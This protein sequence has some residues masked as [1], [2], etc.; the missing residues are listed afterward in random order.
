M[1]VAAN[2]ADPRWYEEI[3]QWLRPTP[4]APPI[5]SAADSRPIGPPVSVTPMRPEGTDSSISNVRL[6][7][8]LARTQR[9]RNSHEGFAEIGIRARSPQTYAAGALLANGARL[10]EIY[11]HYV[12]LE[13]NG[14]TVR[15]DLQG[16]A[17]APAAPT[18]ELLMVGGTSEKEVSMEVSEEPLTTYV[19]PTPLFKGDHLY[20]VALY[21]GR[22]AGVLSD[23][24]LQTGDVLTGINGRPISDA[25]SAFAALRTIAQGALL[26]V[27]VERQG[28]SQPLSLD[29][30]LVTRAI[31][32]ASQPNPPPQLD[33][34][35]PLP[36]SA[37]YSGLLL[38][39]K[40]P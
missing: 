28:V 24:G 14:R 2:P 23:L 36:L 35:E 6:P 32:R 11:D 27:D 39:E 13:R 34:Q 26:N 31:S 16:E 20:G 33:I 15:L 38:P 3:L 25:A 7:L 5:K 10:T 22:E 4:L 21:P 8:L 29:G 17:R 30:S 1:V 12:V 9:G 37:G 19:R 18:D 40:S